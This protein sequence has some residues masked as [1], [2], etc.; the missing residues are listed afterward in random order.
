MPIE[1]HDLLDVMLPHDREVDGIPSGQI[2]VADD[3]LA[4]RGHGLESDRQYLVYH[5]EY[6]VEAGLYRVAAADGDKTVENLLQHLGVSDQSAALGDRSFKESTG[7][8]F[9]RVLGAHEVHGDVGVDQD[10]T[11]APPYP[12]SISATI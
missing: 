6:Q 3:D 9:V 5:L 10:H 1:A 11:P 2:G 8:H 4:G 12:R 7:V